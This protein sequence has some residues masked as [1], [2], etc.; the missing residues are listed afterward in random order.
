MSEVLGP[1]SEMMNDELNQAGTCN[2]CGKP[3]RYGGRHAKCGKEKAGALLQAPAFGRA[4]HKVS[5]EKGNDPQ[6]QRHCMPL[7]D[8]QVAALTIMLDHYKGDPR[9]EC[10]RQLVY[11]PN[12]KLT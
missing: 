3:V 6:P 7:S 11:G 10:L 9:T 5:D 8:E 12:A 1:R 4:A 2:V